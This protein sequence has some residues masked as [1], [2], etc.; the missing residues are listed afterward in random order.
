M[1][2]AYSRSKM[3]NQE[4]LKMAFKVFDRDGDGHIT[5]EELKIAFSGR[6]D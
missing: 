4:N 6:K 2:A 3:V 1:S 5:K